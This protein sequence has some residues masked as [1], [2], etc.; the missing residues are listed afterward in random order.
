[1]KRYEIWW[2][3]LPK[4][5]AR[6]PVLQLSRDSAYSYLCKFLAV[7]ITTNIRNIVEEVVLTTP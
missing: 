6:C 1:M 5:A 4:P 3:S 7:E 2:A